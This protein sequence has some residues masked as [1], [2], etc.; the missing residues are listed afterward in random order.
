[1]TVKELKDVLDLM[2]D[3]AEVEIYVEND[4][5]YIHADITDVIIGTEPNK[6]CIYGEENV[7]AER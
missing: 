4:W 6:V 2:N 3:D 5:S 7:N 1:M